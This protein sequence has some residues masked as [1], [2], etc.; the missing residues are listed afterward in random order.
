LDATADALY[1][2]F[3]RVAQHLESHDLGLL[4]GQS[5]WIDIAHRAHCKARALD[6]KPDSPKLPVTHPLA[7]STA[8]EAKRDGLILLTRPPRYEE[9]DVVTSSFDARILTHVSKN[10]MKLMLDVKAICTGGYIL[11]A[12][13]A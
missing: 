8:Q 12:L 7:R 10:R 4:E 13:E 3:N 9:F 2:G 6:S 11:G 1:T 5:T